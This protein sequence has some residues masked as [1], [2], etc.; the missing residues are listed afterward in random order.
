MEHAH[1]MF[2]KIRSPR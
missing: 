1:S 2:A